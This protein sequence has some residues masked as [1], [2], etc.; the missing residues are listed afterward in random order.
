MISRHKGYRFI[1]HFPD[2]NYHVTAE[3]CTS[4]KMDYV[5]W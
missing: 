5:T 3:Y 2:Q 4:N 1:K